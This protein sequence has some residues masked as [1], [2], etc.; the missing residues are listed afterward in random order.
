MKPSRLPAAFPIVAALLVGCY[1]PPPGLEKEWHR[2]EAARSAYDTCLLQGP[3][4]AF[5]CDRERGAYDDAL[6]EYR[7]TTPR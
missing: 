2:K 7:A 5:R 6:K 4:T 1:H 3:R